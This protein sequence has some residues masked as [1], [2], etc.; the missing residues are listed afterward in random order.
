[1]SEVPPAAQSPRRARDRRVL[2]LLAVA[3]LLLAGWQG[4]VYGA[5][6]L[7]NRR[8]QGSVGKPLPAFRLPTADGG[9]YDS[10][11]LRGKVA[12]LH[13]FRSRCHSCEQEKE[14]VRAFAAGLDPAR[15]VLL[16]ILV[17]RVQGFPEEDSRATLARMAYAHPI[18]IADAAF[19]DAFHGAGWTNVTPITYV[20]DAN[21]TI[22]HALRGQQSAASLRAALPPA[23]RG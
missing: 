8:I 2:W 7:S 22:V 6:A 19:A 21:G 18:L 20:V 4:V 23:P 14:E 1:M 11:A 12:V 16:G 9:Q 10:T 17:D 15:V 13:F 5:R 3:L